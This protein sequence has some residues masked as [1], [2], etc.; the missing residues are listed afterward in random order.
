MDVVVVA[1]EDETRQALFTRRF[2]SERVERAYRE[3]SFQLSKP[4]GFAL[5]LLG[6]G[7]ELYAIVAHH[8]G[9]GKGGLADNASQRV[10]DLALYGPFVLMCC[11]GLFMLSPMN[12]SARLPV[13][14]GVLTTLYVASA[15]G[16][17]FPDVLNGRPAERLDATAWHQEYAESVEAG[18]ARPWHDAL[19]DNPSREGGWVAGAW[20]IAA[21]GAAALGDSGGFSPIG[22]MLF[23]CMVAGTHAMC[24][25]EHLEPWPRD[26]GSPQAMVAH[27]CSPSLYAPVAVA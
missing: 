2:R 1:S 3:H 26:H 5:A 11:C 7:V 6:A 13:V 16:P 8:M 25:A 12:N 24:V 17:S 20:Y 10:S 23:F 15:L 9:D 19:V 22:A 27:A 4:R 18:R 14:I 21:F